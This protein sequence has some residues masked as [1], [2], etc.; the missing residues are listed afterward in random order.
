V[1]TLRAEGAIACTPNATHYEV[2]LECLN[3]GLHLLIEKPLSEDYAQA[4]DL[5]HRAERQG[6]QLAV[7]H[8]YRYRAGFSKA[9]QAVLD[10]RLGE[11]TGGAVEFF[12]W[13]PTQGMAQPLLLNQ[14]VHHFDVL[15]F[16]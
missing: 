9:R 8:Q 1:R 12:R 15:R 7:A 11:L 14:S 16:I 13:R 5:V 3:A 2:A 4:R 6:V 10:G